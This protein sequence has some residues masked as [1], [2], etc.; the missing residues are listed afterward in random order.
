MSPL[1]IVLFVVLGILFLV[2]I[3]ASFIKWNARRVTAWFS[4]KKLEINL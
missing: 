1:L 2:S 4:L 3:V